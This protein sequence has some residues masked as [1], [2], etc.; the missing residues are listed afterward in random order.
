MFFAGIA[1]TLSVVPAAIPL[2]LPTKRTAPSTVTT[3]DTGET[4]PG[5]APPV[6]A[7]ESANWEQ[8]LSKLNQPY[9]I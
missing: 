3:A 1:E 8:V 4:F 9:R 7:P 6:E 2:L 5:P